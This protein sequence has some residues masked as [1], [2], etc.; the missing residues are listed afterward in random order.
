MFGPPSTTNSG[1]DS[2][3]IGIGFALLK[4]VAVSIS[5]PL[6]NHSFFLWWAPTGIG[7]AAGFFE[8]RDKSVDKVSCI[9][10]PGGFTGCHRC[11]H[12]LSDECAGVRMGMA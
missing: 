3:F 2:F 8:Q 1:G 4:L 7:S 12:C 5:L 9:P 6:G 11:M 10:I